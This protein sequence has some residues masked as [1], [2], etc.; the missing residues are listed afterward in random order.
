LLFGRRNP[1]DVIPDQLSASEAPIRDPD[2]S[3]AQ[4]DTPGPELA[5]QA[6]VDVSSLS[7][8]RAC[9]IPDLRFA[10]L[11]LSGMTVVAFVA[12]LPHAIILIFH[13]AKAG[14]NTHVRCRSEGC[15]EVS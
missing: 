4:R 14:A 13:L 5:A 2:I 7:L 11:T 12:F 3:R 6:E 10:P 15:S 8:A 1:T 9:W